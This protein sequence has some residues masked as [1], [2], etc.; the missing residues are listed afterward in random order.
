M[1]DINRNSNYNSPFH[2]VDKNNSKLFFLVIFL[3]STLILE[4]LIR[5]PLHN[6]SLYILSHIDESSRCSFWDDISFFEGFSG[7]VFLLI[8]IVNFKNIY[9]ALAF[10]S[11]SE[12]TIY[13]TNILKLFYYEPQPFWLKANLRPCSCNVNYGNPSNTAAGTMTMFLILNKIFKKKNSSLNNALIALTFGTFLFIPNVARF[14]QNSH[15]INQVLFGFAI[16]Y[17]VYYIFFEIFE[18]NYKDSNQFIYIFYNKY[19]IRFIYFLLVLHII[20]NF[21]FYLIDFYSDKNWLDVITKFC[22]IVPYNFHDNEA[23]QKVCSIMLSVSLIFTMYLEYIL[24]YESNID[25]M[26]KYNVD[27]KNKDKWNDTG[28][29]KTYIRIALMYGSFY[30]IESI[31]FKGNPKIDSFIKL[32]FLRYIL[33]NIVVGVHLFL[34]CKFLMKVLNLTNEHHLSKITSPET[35]PTNYTEKLLKNE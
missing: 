22:D 3:I 21:M 5:R 20:N 14:V 31:F 27:M 6:L 24:I 10:I 19:M 30:Y 13:F 28:L 12:F 32:L 1:L 35:S 26:I 29:G 8:L 7:K 4:T 34:I 25:E 17:S 16:G 33:I 9:A 15:S 11:I 23:Y 18:I 2:K